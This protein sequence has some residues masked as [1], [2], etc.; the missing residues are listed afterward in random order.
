M[1]SAFG[2]IPIGVSQMTASLHV[3]M[4]ANAAW[5]ILHFRMPV[6]RDLIA[7][8][9]RLTVL[10]PFDAAVPE[11]RAAG[12]TV[13]PLAMS[14]KGISPWQDLALLRQYR[15]VFKA[16]RPD[17]ILGYTIKPNIY[18][19]MVATALGLPFL[20]NVSGLGTG[21]LSGGGLQWVAE[22][23]YRHAFAA[24]PIVFF[25]NDEDSAFFCQRGLIRA[26][27]ARVLPGS[28]IDLAHFAAAATPPPGQPGVFLMIARLLRDKG[29]Y[30][31]VAAARK[32]RAL[33]PEL[34]FQLLGEMG[35]ANRSAISAETLAAWRNEGIIDY[36]GQTEDVRPYI[37]AADCVVLPSYR[38]GAPRVLI[39]AAAMARPVIASDVP[40]C[41]AVVQ[42]GVTGLLCAA[43]DAESL[44]QA[45][46][47]FLTLPED[48]KTA[49]REAARARMEHLYDQA[50]VIA[51]YRAACAALT[52]T[53]ALK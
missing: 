11:L 3:L 40:G 35:A 18:G 8:G 51:A 5:N 14:V 29:V 9:H 16:Q 30:E 39:E 36:L 10:A 47:H 4:T 45:C 15:R 23:L 19:A 32:L 41:R 53:A 24:L 1:A 22:R 48:H 42:D 49:M 7:S 28:G 46:L 26:E 20:P 37:A 52:G 21:F 43:R 44:T 6:V 31:Y 50:H 38:E 12:C 34:R 13:L 27:Q 25:Q 33:H 17:L 2:P